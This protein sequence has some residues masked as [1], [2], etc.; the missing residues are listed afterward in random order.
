MLG[1]FFGFFLE[2][3]RQKYNCEKIGASQKYLEIINDDHFFFSDNDVW[4]CF[5]FLSLQKKMHVNHEIQ[6]ILSID[7]RMLNQYLIFLES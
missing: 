5:A 6:L 2:E 4:S 1:F 3:G 7:Q